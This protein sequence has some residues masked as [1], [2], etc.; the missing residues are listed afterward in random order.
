MR[1]LRR[2]RNRKLY[3]PKTSK[4]LGL[5]DLTEIIRRGE[6]VQVLDPAGKDQTSY[7]LATYLAKMEQAHPVPGTSEKLQAL[8]SARFSQPSPSPTSP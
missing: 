4:Y 2:Y 3:D 1:T 7:V 8:L 5:N 6:T